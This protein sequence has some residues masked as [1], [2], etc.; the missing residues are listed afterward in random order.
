LNP[1]GSTLLQ[2]VDFIRSFGGG[3]LF[4][5]LN[6]ALRFSMILLEGFRAYLYSAE[7][8][9]SFTGFKQEVHSSQ[10]LRK[11]QDHSSPPPFAK[12]CRKTEVVSDETKNKI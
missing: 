1:F 2:I 9:K 5:S 10:K 3:L 11:N 7:N 8:H 4:E 6:Y 12:D